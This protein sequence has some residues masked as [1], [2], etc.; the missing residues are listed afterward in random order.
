MNNYGSY[1]K[2]SL[3][4]VLILIISAGSTA[5]NNNAKRNIESYFQVLPDSCFNLCDWRNGMAEAGIKTLD[6]KNGYIGFKRNEQ[7]PDFFQ[8]ALFKTKNGEDFVAV[9]NREC[10]AFA[11]FN[12]RSYFFRRQEDGWVQADA[13]FFS[14]INTRMFYPDTAVYHL[15]DNYAGYF[16][17][18]YILPRKGK[19]IKVELEVCEYIAIDHPEVSESDYEK[20]VNEKKIVYL[21]WDPR[22]GRFIVLAKGTKVPTH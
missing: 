14:G 4:A 9:S 5:Q 1:K 21:L 11:C 20:L 3:L 17:F 8:A 22:A 19:L 10:E 12:P 13:G 6:N 7:E 16:K 15:L 18:N 2:S